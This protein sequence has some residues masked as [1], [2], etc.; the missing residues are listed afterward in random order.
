MVTG[1]AMLDCRLLKD[2]APRSQPLRHLHQS[3]VLRSDGPDGFLKD[4]APSRIQSWSSF[5]FK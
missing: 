4:F 1:R 3:N 2:P 5:S